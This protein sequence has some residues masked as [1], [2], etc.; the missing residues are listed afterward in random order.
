MDAKNIAKTL[1]LDNTIEKLA[2][3]EAFLTLKDYKPNLYNNPKCRL[4][5]LTKSEIGIISKKL[6]DRIKSSIRSSTGFMQWRNSSAVISWFQ[7]IPRKDMCKFLKFD[8]VDFYPSITEDLLT[9]L[10]E[11]AQN[12]VEADEHTANII[13]HCRQSI[14]FS[15]V[16]A[17]SKK[18]SPHFDVAMGSFDVVEACELV[19]LYMLYHLSSVI[20]DKMNIGLYRDD[21]L[22]I[23]EA[24]SGPE[25]DRIRKEIEKLFKDHH[26]HI[27]TELGLIQT[28]F[29]DVTF[30][31]KSG[32]YW[33]YRK[34]ND[35]PL[36]INAGSNHPP[37][38]KKQ[39]P[40]MLSKRLSELSCNRE[41]FEKAATPY[42][43]AIKTSGYH[44]GLAYDDHATDTRARRRNRKRN[45][46]WFNTPL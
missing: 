15:K 27:T 7:K 23:L 37:M 33:P 11:F 2:K 32:K 38:I 41:E 42:N 36:Y 21:G 22:A 24:T 25:T 3:K 14:L 4:I 13:M 40:S 29:L 18:S 28:D 19:G 10:L 17:W 26:L 39:L 30:N 5:N 12:Y 1:K 8:I 34:P 20:G 31:L 9:K 44:E 35:Q 46:V 16:N 6:L 43:T 45:I